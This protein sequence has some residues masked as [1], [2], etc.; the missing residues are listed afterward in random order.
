MTKP[1]FESFGRYT[2]IKIKSKS[3]GFIATAIPL[4][5]RTYV[6]KEKPWR[7]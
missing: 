4:H 7:T 5:F 2:I 3:K 6:H 1:K